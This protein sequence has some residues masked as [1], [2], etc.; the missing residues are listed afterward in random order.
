MTNNQNLEVLAPDV[1]SGWRDNFVIELRLQGVSGRGT[2]AAL[3]EVQAHC[4][5]SGQEVGDAFGPPVGYARALELPDK[6]RWTAPQIARTWISILLL[7]GG[8]SATLLGGI[9]LGRGERVE[10]NGGLITNGATTVA[11]MALVFVVGSH[12]LRFLVDHPVWTALGFGAIVAVIPLAGLP[13]RD[14]HVGSVSAPATLAAG[15][16]ALAAWAVIIGVARRRGKDLRDPLVP[17]V[18]GPDP[19]K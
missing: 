15:L 10:I 19:P 17:P 1:E 7:V 9:S 2:A 16:A 3:A 8:V 6:S 11:V 5:D 13:F 12:L 4:R 18:P 14:F